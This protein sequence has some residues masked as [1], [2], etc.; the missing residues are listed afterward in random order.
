MV[1]IFSATHL[2]RVNNPVKTPAPGK[3][4]LIND[5]RLVRGVV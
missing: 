5:F 4:D 3:M 1:S 2:P